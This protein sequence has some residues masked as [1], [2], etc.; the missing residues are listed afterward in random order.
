MYT[1]KVVQLFSFLF[2]PR[3]QRLGLIKG[4][5]E[6]RFRRLMLNHGTCAVTK[7]T[8]GEPRVCCPAKNPAQ[9][10]RGAQHNTAPYSNPPGPTA[11]AGC[12]GR[13]GCHAEGPRDVFSATADWVVAV[14]GSWTY[15]VDTIGFRSCPR[16]PPPLRLSER[17][18]SNAWMLTLGRTQRLRAQTSFGYEGLAAK[19]NKQGQSIKDMLGGEP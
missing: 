6:T 3:Q 15:P 13:K 14:E 19:R 17:E 9:A 11:A 12:P 4:T 10:R 7:P 2:Q 18:C 5:H 8:G 16:E 1:S